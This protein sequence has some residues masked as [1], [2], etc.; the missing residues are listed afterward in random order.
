MP[1]N[2]NLNNIPQEILEH[3]ALCTVT[4]KFLG[5]PA[6]I[7]PLLLINRRLHSCLSASSSPHLYAR[8][9]AFKYDVATVIRRLGPERT[10]TTVLSAELQRRCSHLTRIR[11]RTDTKIIQ[12]PFVQYDNKM[13]HA[14]LWMGY[15]MMLEN[16]G[17]NEQ[18]LRDYAEMDVWLKEYWFDPQGASSATLSIRMNKWPPN[19]AQNSL[20]MWLFWFLLD[21]GQSLCTIVFQTG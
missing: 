7:I 11:C 17:K 19:S 2:L 10:S 18:Q 5:P 16:N 4:T 3:I 15:L 6:A 14:I 1:A 20:A 12:S 21:P 9:F 8:I 13:V